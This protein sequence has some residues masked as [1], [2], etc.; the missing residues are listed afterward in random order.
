[1]VFRLIANPEG[2][3][4]TLQIRGARASKIGSRLPQK[5]PR[6]FVKKIPVA[7]ILM[8]GEGGCFGASFA[9]LTGDLIR[10]STPV[11]LGPH[12]AFLSEYVNL[13][14][15]IFSPERFVLTSYWAN[16]QRCI[17]MQGHYF[18]FR[19]VDRVIELARHFAHMLNRER[20]T[21]SA[22]RNTR[23][24]MPVT[25]RRIKFSDCYEVVDGNHRLALA[26]FCGDAHHPCVVLT[27][28]PMLTPIQQMIMDSSWT[29]GAF[30]LYQPVD[31]PEFSSWPVVRR[32]AD[33]LLM[34]RAFLE[35][36]GL[37]P[38]S[39]LDVCSSYGWFVHKMSKQG[40]E[41]FGVDR[42]ASA[43]AVGI[44]AYALNP[45]AIAIEDVCTFLTRDARKYDVVSCFS[46]LHH[47]ALG[48]GAISP[49]E[50]IRLVD[51]VT[52][53]VLFIDTGQAH[54]EWFKDTLKEWTAE[55]IVGWLRKHTSFDSIHVLG[56]DR[57]NQGI[58][59]KQYGRH[60]FACVRS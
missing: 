3:Q 53:R 18:S 32:C 2:V 35:Q 12:A 56:R 7:N 50:F 4:V 23:R 51:G 31:L 45:S 15:D 6:L 39:Y 60:L 44:L 1:M 8:G 49:V 48:K 17:Q 14:E 55:H 36:L 40:C 16:A 34:M 11:T 43:V 24:R 58:Y 5:L 29:E 54:E 33:R 37:R 41:A 26:A 10:P 30:C 22:P 9:R 25:V 38:E 57:D 27:S 20:V 21:Y 47:F 59:R 28:E 46:I 52:G 19:T 42:D 13:G